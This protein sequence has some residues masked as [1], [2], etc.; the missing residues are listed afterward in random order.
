MIVLGYEDMNEIP[1]NLYL[2][3]LRESRL[4]FFYIADICSVTFEF[5]IQIMN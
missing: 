2:L 4:T 5:I 3:V 1:L